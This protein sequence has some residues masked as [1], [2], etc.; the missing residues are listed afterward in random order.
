MH[1]MSLAEGIVELVEATAR[2]EGAVRVRRIFVD[3][4]ELATVEVEALTFCFAAVAEGTLA[5]GATLEVNAVAGE[6]WCP[7]CARSVPLAVIYGEC[8]RCG[9]VRVQPTAGTE[10]RVREI[11]IGD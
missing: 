4:G 11:E 2:R 9:G 7:D 5:A 10:M 8:P 6:G 3:I 1:E